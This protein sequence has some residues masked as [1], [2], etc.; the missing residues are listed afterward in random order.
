MN[1]NG[2]QLAPVAQHQNTM[3]VG[4]NFFDPA[5]KE[6]LSMLAHSSLV[7]ESYRI[8][9]IVGGK[10]G[11][12]PKKTVSEQEAVAN[13]IIAFD[14]ASRIGA[15]PLM[16]MQN[17]Y[18]VYGRPSWSSKFLI[19]TINTCGRFEPLKFEMTNVGVCSNNVANVKCV[20]WTTPKGVTRE[21]DGSPITSRAQ[22]ALRGT[23]VTIQMAV[24]EG[25][26][27]KNGSKWHTMPEQMLRYRAASFWCATYA[28]E[29]SMG[30][31]T[32]EES[33]EEADFVDVTAQVENEFNAQA[34]KKIIS[35]D[36]GDPNGSTTT[37]TAVDTTTGEIITTEAVV[38][39]NGGVPVETGE[40]GDDG[41]GY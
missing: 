2:Q 26:Y 37:A 30:M 39:D 7:P 9:G 19:A 25:W 12:G 33:V 28:P 5:V 10:T 29:L 36:E 6:N 34:N 17:L 40:Q 15:S 23:A 31:K 21:A 35:F 8:G 14:V 24:D 32:V 13:C 16:V 22:Q 18:I 27:S 41:P 20:A 38:A 11:E 3:P 4:I 1:N